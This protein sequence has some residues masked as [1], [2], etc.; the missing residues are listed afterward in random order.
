MLLWQQ[1]LD[2]FSH[3][4]SIHQHLAKIH[5]QLRVSLLSF[6]R[7]AVFV[8]SL[9]YIFNLNKN[10]N[11][12]PIKVKR[13]AE[14]FFV[15][16]NP[17]Q[18]AAGCYDQN[19]QNYL[20]VSE[21]VRRSRYWLSLPPLPVYCPELDGDL[22]TLP[23]IFEDQYEDIAEFARRRSVAPNRKTGSGRYISPI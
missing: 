9:N 16:D 1:F 14:A 20:A 12:F 19:Y 3:R 23:I 15:L 4:E 13:F 18:S 21:L 7:T 10:D 5:H 2:I 22:N 8:L 11:F 17:R 6:L